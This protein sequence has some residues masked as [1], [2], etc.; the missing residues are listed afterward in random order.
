MVAFSDHFGAPMLLWMA[1]CG[2]RIVAVNAAMD[3]SLGKG[4]KQMI[5]K[6]LL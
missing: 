6:A 4:L 5:Q 1:F 3:K 2:S